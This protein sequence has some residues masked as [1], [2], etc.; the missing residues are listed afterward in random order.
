[1]AGEDFH[2]L[3]AFVA[4][5]QERSFTRAAAKLG[6]SQSALSQ[7]VQ[8]LRSA[9]WCPAA[10]PNHAQRIPDRRRRPPAAESR[11]PF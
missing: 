2:D 8:G 1:M 7:T 10:E 5:A 4:V 9:D 6:V 3:T 11:P